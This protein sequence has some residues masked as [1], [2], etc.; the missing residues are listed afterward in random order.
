MSDRMA[1]EEAARLAAEEERAEEEGLEQAEHAAVDN[2]A[3]GTP[4]L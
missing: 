2:T 3:T 1:R 4:F